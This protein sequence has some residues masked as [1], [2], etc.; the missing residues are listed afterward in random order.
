MKIP[1]PWVLMTGPFYQAWLVLPLEHPDLSTWIGG[2]RTPEFS[3]YI[4]TI[5]VKLPIIIADIFCALLVK[6]IASE[7]GGRRNGMFAATVWLLNPYVLL[8]GEMNGSIELIPVAVM[9]A[10]VMLLVKGRGA[11]GS[12]ALGIGVALKLF[13]IFLTPALVIYYYRLK[14]TKELLEIVVASLVGFSIY[15]FWISAWGLQFASSLLFYTPFTTTV[16]QLILTPYASKIG[17]AT[18]STLVFLFVLGMY[19]A[20]KENNT[21]DVV[22]GLLLAY[23]AFVDWWPQYLL[24]LIPLLTVDAVISKGW[25]KRYLFFL[26]TSAF[27]FNLISFRFA[28][29]IDAFYIPAFTNELIALSGVLRGIYQNAALN[30]AISPMLRSIFAGIAILYC[31]EIC[32]RNSPRLRT[33]LGRVVSE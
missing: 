13:P 27:F 24:W 25:G 10:G 19:W 28:S 16:S 7:F 5:M 33:L 20:V 22:C 1:V 14:R 21:F 3:G 8:T 26:L 29:E 15:V 32:M 12:V 31:A 30:L 2:M 6:E 11:V 9:L 4:L 18:I 23:M 17:L